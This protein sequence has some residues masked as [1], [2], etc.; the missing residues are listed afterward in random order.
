M[1]LLGCADS[2]ATLA[3]WFGWS[4]SVATLTWSPCSL[5]CC[6]GSVTLHPSAAAVA[7]LAAFVGLAQSLRSLAGWCRS[8]VALYA[9]ALVQRF[10]RS[11]SVA[12][13]TWLPQWL[14]SIGCCQVWSLRLLDGC[15]GSVTAHSARFVGELAQSQRPPYGCYRSVTVLLRP[16]HRLGSLLARPLR[17]I[18]R[19]AHSAA[20][21]AVLLDPCSRCAH[22]GLRCI[23]RCV[24]SVSYVES[25]SCC[26]HLVIC[27]GSVVKV[28]RLLPALVTTLAGWLDG[29]AGLV[30]ALT[31]RLRLLC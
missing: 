11:R 15:A 9:A 28:D 20:A 21:F 22:S 16:L 7:E 14:E 29:C 23:G 18:G 4:R 30:T 1:L 5:R 2:A 10:S 6:A 17:W 12:V 13:L 3:Q 27:A 26:A 31:T 25:P 19:Y 8:V 24:G